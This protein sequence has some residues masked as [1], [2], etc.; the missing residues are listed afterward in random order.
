MPE[1]VSISVV[2]SGVNI[3]AGAV[4]SVTAGTGL[5][6]GNITS[7]GTIAADFAAS[8][9]AT[10]NKVVEA[11]DSR[12]SNARTP[13]THGSSHGVSGSDPIPADGIAQSQVASLTTDLAAKVPT[14]RQVIA[15]DGLLGGGALSTNVSL[16]VLFGAVANTVC[17][18]NDARLTNSRTPDV[19]AS[20]H[21]TGGSDV[22][23]LGQSQITNL[24]TDLAARA[25]GATTMTA[26]TGLTGGGDLTANRTFSVAYGTTSTTAT[27]GNDSRLSFIASGTGATTLTLQNKLRDV[28]SVKDFGAVGDGSTDDTTAISNAITAAMGK[29][30][31]FPAGTYV[32]TQTGTNQISKT[33][34]GNLTLNGDNATIKAIP[35]TQ[36]NQ[37]LYFTQVNQYNVEVSG[38]IFDANQKAQ[39]ILRFDNNSGTAGSATALVTIDNCEFK[40]CLGVVGGV[41]GQTGVIGVLI[42]GGYKRVS[43]TNT[44]I[45]NMNRNTSSNVVGST[46]TV[47]LAISP[48][49]TLYCESANISGCLVADILNQETTGNSYNQD[50]DG[51]SLFGGLNDAGSTYVPC[52]YTITN[53]TFV[54]CKGRAIKIQSD[55]ANV[56]NNVFRFAIRPCASANTGISSFGGIVNFQVQAGTISNNVWHYDPAPGNTNPFSIT[57]TAGDAGSGCV[58]FFASG[59]IARPR[60]ITISG[61][62]VY[63]NVPEAVGAMMQ[64]FTTT[65]GS[66]PSGASALPMFVTIKENRILA[67]ACKYFLNTALRTSAAGT[68]YMTISDNAASKMQT[69][70]MC[71]PSSGSYDNNVIVCTNNIN[72]SGTDVLHLENTGTGTNYPAKITALNNVGIGLEADKIRTTTTAFLPRTG[73]VSPLESIGSQFSMQTV[74]LAAGADYTF[75]QRTYVANGGLRLITGTT[76]G[77]DVNAMFS[78]VSGTLNGH[79]TGSNAVVVHSTGAP[80]SSPANRIHIGQNGGLVQVRNTFGSSYIIT[81]FSWG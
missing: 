73:G 59:S 57:N 14:T 11:T 35:S 17:E 39:S 56:S 48:A 44:R 41:G 37:M 63:N 74:T 52:S 6:G 26:G 8:G 71:N 10:A 22:L 28:L 50:T 58:G 27:V 43:I 69:A 77:G 25:L 61:N 4:T 7:S 23:T 62:V 60:S 1:Q 42:A 24:T 30:L 75:P 32:L 51:L 3:A 68:L 79:F 45:L 33:L 53:N 78:G 76:F 5:T 38:L 31:F 34:S 66:M 2:S 55:E 80:P 81:L 46:G 13:T 20:T 49:S 21:A 72:A 18:G 16:E 9:S 54:N 64:L 36:V 12:L 65:E 29:T 15:G 67:G 40:N 19:H 70:F 47:G